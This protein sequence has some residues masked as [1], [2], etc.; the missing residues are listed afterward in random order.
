MNTQRP[1]HFD[2]AKVSIDLNDL[3]WSNVD[4][5]YAWNLNILYKAVFLT[6]KII[7]PNRLPD[8]FSIDVRNSYAIEF[9]Q[10]LIRNFDNERESELSKN[11]LLNEFLLISTI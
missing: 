10:K 8:Q 9:I 2:Y 4:G 1:E 5:Q 3:I 11:V 6:W 7:P